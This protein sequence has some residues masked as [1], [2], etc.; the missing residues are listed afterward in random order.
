M[1]NL[2]LAALT[3]TLAA[4]GQ[5]DLAARSRTPALTAQGVRTSSSMNNL[6]ISGTAVYDLSASTC[7][8]PPGGYEDFVSYPGL[9]LSGS[10]QGCLYTKVDTHKE[11]P[12]G[13]Y[14]E[15]GREVFVG[16]LNGG[17][18]GVFAT[19]YT[20]ESKFSMGTEVRGRCQH[21]LVAGS[22]TGGFAGA[23]GR[24]DLKDIVAD[25]SDIYYIY[26]GHISLR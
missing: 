23:T 19:T 20:F 18:I 10:L 15:E 21:P 9:V 24:L 6:Q 25:P 22:G 26:R 17:P 13:V 14:L 16:S 7:S 5:T 1:R 3:F 2:L 8:G 12:S 11:T 4:C